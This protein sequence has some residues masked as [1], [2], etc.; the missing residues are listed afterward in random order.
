MK[1]K[2][3]K[4]KVCRII[5]KL[6]HIAI[7]KIN[8]SLTRIDKRF[9]NVEQKHI[10]ELNYWRG[11]IKE[12]ICVRDHGATFEEIFYQWQ[13]DRILQLSKALGLTDTEEI[14]EWCSMRSVIE[15]GAGPYP[16]IATTRKGW[17]RAVAVDPLAR[18]YIE[19]GLLTEKAKEIVYIEAPGEKI[20]LP[21]GFA[22]IIINENSLDHVS[23]P[24]SVVSEMMR[25]LK[26]DG[27]LWLFVDLSNYVD[28]MHPHAMNEE[29]VRK[30]LYDFE[31]IH[32]TVNDHHAHPEAYGSYRGL[33]RKS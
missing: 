6:M 18:S 5:K 13:R 23:S 7:T 33:F 9:L 15:I 26:P 21:S 20:P 17:L 32:E 25:L 4:Q 29:K 8:T 28:N 27:F 1:I 16:A 22:D 31:L 3:F 10:G 24:E 14:D 12:G 30:F 11:F 2:W 19:E